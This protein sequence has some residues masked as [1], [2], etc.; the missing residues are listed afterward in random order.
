MASPYTSSVFINCPFDEAYKP[1]FDAIVFSALDSG[2]TPRCSMEIDDSAQ[3]R[4]DKIFR[5][6]EECKYAIHDLSRTDPDPE[7]NLPRFNMP[8]ELGM[9]LG[10]RHAGQNHHREKACLV[11]DTERFRYQKFISDISGQDI[12]AHANDPKTAVGLVRDWLNAKTRR[13]TIPGK[14]TIWKR[15]EEFIAGLPSICSDARLEVDEMTY[16]DFVDFASGWL[17]EYG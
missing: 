13:R 11:L 10:V 3:V 14:T 4:I 12:K 5:I 15:F 8:L 6:I 1:I 7:H 16:N 17:E 2:F 9:F